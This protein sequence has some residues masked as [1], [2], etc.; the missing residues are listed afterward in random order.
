MLQNS[1]EQKLLCHADYKISF[2]EILFKNVEKNKNGRLR[3]GKKVLFDMWIK[4]KILI[5]LVI[6]LVGV[7]VYLMPFRSFVLNR[8]IFQKIQEIPEDE[9]IYLTNFFKYSFFLSSFGYTVFGTKPMSFDTVNLSYSPDLKNDENYMDIFHIFD[10]HK[11][12]KCW[13]TWQKYSHLFPFNGFSMISVQSPISQ[14]I[15]EV[16]IINHKNFLNTVSQNLSDFQ[17]VLGLELTPQRILE[18]YIKGN[19]KVFSKIR[20]HDGLFGTLLGFGRNNSWEYMSKQK[21]KGMASFFPYSDPKENHI[22]KPSCAVLET[23]ETITLRKAY[24]EQG[25]EIDKIYQSSD[26][27]EQVLIKLS[28]G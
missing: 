18:E 5:F 7:P 3:Q 15:I 1:F 4:N 28:K 26:F 14:D 10:R 6:C 8:T 12:K 16:A 20:L 9:R 13:E 24:E 11:Y 2:I 23:A 22:S 17:K 21:R 25:L 19:G 27:L